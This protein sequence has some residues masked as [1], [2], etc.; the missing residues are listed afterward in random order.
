MSRPEDSAITEWSMT[1]STGT[2]GLM[3]V[4][5]PPIVARA[6]RMA[7]RSTTAGTPVKS[8]M[9]TRSGLKAISVGE[10]DPASWRL[11]QL[12]TASMSAACT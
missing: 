9:S 4:G 2:S 7:A 11:A 6:S 3:A 12:A 5:S 10:S 1:S 8:C